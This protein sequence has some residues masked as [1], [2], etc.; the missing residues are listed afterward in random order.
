MH[1]KLKSLTRG[2]GTM[3][4][5]ILG[6]RKADLV[7]MDILVKGNRVD[8]LST[9]VHRDQADR[10]GRGLVKRLKEEI[11]KH[12]F[13]IP[14]QAALG[15]RIIARENDSSFTQERDRQMLWWRHHPETKTVGQTKRR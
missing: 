10:R 6:F 8:A 12:M 15:G 1:D 7:K 4:Y 14:I 11:S 9:I 13:E 3:D 2:Y 5:E